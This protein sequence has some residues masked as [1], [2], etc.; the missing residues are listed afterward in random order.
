MESHLLIFPGLAIDLDDS[1]YK[2]IID[3]QDLRTVSSISNYSFN[4]AIEQIES[5]NFDNIAYHSGFL[6]SLSSFDNPSTHPFT[7]GG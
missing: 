6:S 5:G 4:R 1:N 7:Y 3:L 2:K